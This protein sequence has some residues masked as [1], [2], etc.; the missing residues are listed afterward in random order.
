[1]TELDI[2]KKVKKGDLAVVCALLLILV[3]FFA[4]KTLLP[5]TE[6]GY[7]EITVN[8]QPYETVSLS[9]TRIFTIQTAGNK[10]NT[11]E[12]KDGTIRVTDAS[13][14]DGLCIRQGGVHRKGESIVCLPNGVVITVKEGENGSVDFING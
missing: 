11:I 1:M 12:I 7:A 13:C 3:A 4:M 8:G 9:D 5:S 6:N 10:S 2:K 14:P